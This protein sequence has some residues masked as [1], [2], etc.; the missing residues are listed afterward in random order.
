MVH[1]APDGWERKPVSK[2]MQRF[3]SQDSE[4]SILYSNENQD[5]HRVQRSIW[6]KDAVPRRSSTQNIDAALS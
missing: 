6:G 4:E 3:N 5:V 2:G 1:Q